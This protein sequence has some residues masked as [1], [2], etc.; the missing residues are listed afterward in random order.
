MNFWKGED[1]F[2]MSNGVIYLQQQEL[3]KHVVLL[4]ILFIACQ[5]LYCAK[6]NCRRKRVMGQIFYYLR[7]IRFPIIILFD[8][9]LNKLITDCP[10]E[11]WAR[12]ICFSHK[13]IDIV[14]ILMRDVCKIT[15]LSIKAPEISNCYVSAML[16]H[17]NFLCNLIH[18]I[19]SHTKKNMT[20]KV[21]FRLKENNIIVVHVVRSEDI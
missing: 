9:L 5:V 10:I 3:I 19:L 12:G 14:N 17:L 13:S 7:S 11:K 16:K 15:R 21:Y 6:H 4:I 8:V 1:N 2:C 20:C 18:I